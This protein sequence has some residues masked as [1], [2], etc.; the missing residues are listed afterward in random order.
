[1]HTPL[2][3]VFFMPS[4]LDFK[5]LSQRQSADWNTLDRLAR[6]NNT[7]ISITQTREA[8]NKLNEEL[9]ANLVNETFKKTIQEMT[10][11]AQ[12]SVDIVIRN[13]FERTADIGFLA[14]D[15]DIRNFLKL[16]SQYSVLNKSEETEY[17]SEKYTQL[18]MA[19][20][21]LEERFQ[22][23]VSKY[24]VY[25]D[26]VLF[27]TKG[28]ILARL[29]KN[30][31]IKV[32]YDSF[33]QE[34]LYTQKDFV[35]TFSYSD[36]QPNNKE[37]LIYSFK[38]TNS[39]E[40]QTPLGVLSL[41]FKFEDEM[42][43]VF[44][45]LISKNDWMILTLLDKDGK[46][47][48]SSD[49]YQ[50]PLGVIQEKEVEK[51][52]SI[53][54]FAGR[55][56]LVKTC[57]TK[58]YEGFYGLGWL[59][60]ALI[61]LDHA[62]EKNTN[63][64]LKSMD[65]EFLESVIRTSSL[66]TKEIKNIPVL[67]EK[68]Q[69]ELDRTVYNGKLIDESGTTGM[70]LGEISE[71]GFKTKQIFED[72]IKNLNETIISSFISNAEFSARL[73]ID[74]MD[75]NLYE[76]ANDCRW[77]ALAEDFRKILSEEN[78][79]EKQK[80]KL[81]DILSYIN[82]LYTVYTNLFL[83]DNEGKILAISLPKGER[84]NEDIPFLKK[85]KWL[86]KSIEEAW[87][88]NT[89]SINNSQQ[90]SVSP[91]A[92]TPLYRE[93]EYTYIYGASIRDMKDNSVL[94]GIGIIFDSMPQF[95]AMLEDVLPKVENGAIQK[96]CIALFADKNK[97]I[98]SSSNEAFKVGSKIDIEDKYFDLNNGESKAGILTYNGQNYALGACCSQ[99]YREYKSLE[100]SYK[101]DIIAFVLMLI[102]VKEEQTTDIKTSQKR[103]KLLIDIP[104]EYDLNSH[105][106]KVVTFLIDGE[107]F[108]L[109]TKNCEKTISAEGVTP[110]LSNDDSY[111]VGFKTYKDETLY[112]VKM[113]HDL[114]TTDKFIDLE[115]EI[116]VVKI[117]N[118]PYIKYIGILTSQI[119]EIKSF[120]NTMIDS[121]QGLL[122]NTEFFS[123][124][125]IK[126]PS[127]EEGKMVTLIDLE[128]IASRLVKPEN[129]KLEH[130]K[131]EA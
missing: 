115:D 98:I 13:L 78:I 72:S 79:S 44:A 53:I 81:E 19:Q 93:E 1:M 7:G 97:N 110:I 26:I 83:Y 35:E 52:Y 88:S 128:K 68:I 85:D 102:G 104:K 4:V 131:N 58:G 94:G 129:I 33:I 21:N 11:K 111:V 106:T 112:I 50:I 39:N 16:K 105:C 80:Q 73:A 8:F 82:N 30:N 77:W 124:A 9:L 118:N 84:V 59:G 123:T 51:E 121:L 48:A 119:G 66:F 55:E 28:K 117:A 5:T 38:V 34:S 10:S 29:D 42:K 108:G 36:L 103:E 99:G 45:N 37:S 14:T 41:F 15:E 125:I 40:D 114:K 12:V 43:G 71:A 96:G 67:A 22:E 27:D 24:S 64:A 56:Y 47:I 126:N 101:N 90:Y 76:R 18:Q 120:P 2:D 89:L 25:Y 116:V 95:K 100:D 107:W 92:K 130:E 69:K 46:V 32:T 74:I 3:L 61:P 75:R 86:N 49:E 20:K 6:I 54:K 23:Y 70:V 109:E 60:H 91:F 113:T 65:G 87:I 31:D 63:L 17:L 127:S 62:F 57:P 122:A